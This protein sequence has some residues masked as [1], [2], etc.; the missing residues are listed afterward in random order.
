MDEELQQEIERIRAA[1]EWL[2]EET[3]EHYAREALNN[4][5]GHSNN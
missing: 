2:D 3:I 5:Y 4:K 1:Y